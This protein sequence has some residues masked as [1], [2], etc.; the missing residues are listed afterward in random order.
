M[1]ILTYRNSEIR[2]FDKGRDPNVDGQMTRNGDH[3]LIKSGG[4]VHDLTNATEVVRKAA[5]ETIDTAAV[6]QDQAAQAI[7]DKLGF[8]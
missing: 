6:L 3:V 2:L 7:E 4:R 1:G 5:D 8:L